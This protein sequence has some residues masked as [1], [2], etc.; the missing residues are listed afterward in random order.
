LNHTG[1]P[2]NEWLEQLLAGEL[3]ASE[4]D[5]VATHLDGCPRCQDRVEQLLADDSVRTWQR[6]M[7]ARADP[8]PPDDFLKSMLQLVP[9]VATSAVALADT[10]GGPEGAPR[11]EPEACPQHVGGYEIVS[12]LGRG[13]M[14]V[15]YKA[16]QPGLGR[17]VAL[18]RLAPRE[19]NGPD[20]ARFLREAAAVARMHHPNIVQVY[21]V[22]Q[23][24]GRPFLALEYLPGGT[25]AEYLGGTPADPR[26][27]ADLLEKV[28]R[29]VHHAHERGIIHRDLKPSNILLAREGE[30]SAEPGPAGSAR[31]SPSRGLVPKVSDFGLAR[32]VTEDQ[33]LTLP[34]VLVG[35]PAYLAPE[36]IRQ[37]GLT[38]PAGD[39][40]ALGVILY[41]MLTGRPPLVGPTTLATLRLVEA[42]EPV[43]PSRLQPHLP[44][45][46]DTIA[47][48]CLHKDPRRRY[49][50]ALEVAEE[51]RRF[52]DGRPIRARPV[53]RLATAWLWCRRNPVVA[54]LGAALAAS[55]L[56]GLAV[57]LVLLGQARRSAA[58][59]GENEARALAAAARAD[60]NARL[61][62][63]RAYTSDLQ[64][65]SQMW[66]NRQY[67]VLQDVLDGQRP[68][69]TDGT[70]RR[71]FEWHFLWAS[72]HRPHRS[73]GLRGQGWD[74]TPSRSGGYLAVAVGDPAV[75]LL[76]AAGKPV[77]TL[78]ATGPKVIRVAVSA[79]GRRVAGGSED[80][81]TRVWE[82]DSG[83]LLHTLAGHRGP[84][85]GLSFLPDGGA[86]V[87]V[88]LDGTLRVWNLDDRSANPRVISRPAVRFH[89]ATVSPDGK[90]VAVGGSD[91]A[92]RLW[93]T[94]TW[95]EQQA[96]RGHA[97]DVLS[98]RFGPDSVLLASGSRD[99]TARLHDTATGKAVRVLAMHLDAVCALDFSPDGRTLATASLDRSIQVVEVASGLESLILLGHTD[100]VTGVAFGLD[101]K[102]L[103]S[104]GWD[105]T[106]RLWDLTAGRPYRLWRGHS[107]SVRTVAFAPHGGGLA[108]GSLDGT[109]RVWDAVTGAQRQ[110]FSGHTGGV[111]SLAV[112]DGG[113]LATAAGDSRV[114]VWD[115]VAGRVA[116]TLEGHT[117]RV[118]AVSFGPGGR[119]L[120]GAGEGGTLYVWDAAGTWGCQ[121]LAKLPAAVACVRFDPTGSNLAAGCRDGTVTVLEVATG[122]RRQHLAGHAGAVTALDFSPDGRRLAVASVDRAIR[123]WDGETGNLTH[124]LRGHVRAVSAVCFSPDGS[125]L[126]SGSPDQTVRV[127]HAESWQPLVILTEPEEVTTLAVDPDE[128]TVVSAGLTGSIR[129]RRAS[130]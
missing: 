80:G 37:P 1:C 112:A 55:V 67:S 64:F 84:V 60:A 59:A 38:T 71:G 74:M 43:P 102:T 125:R 25:L 128:P 9:L 123:I 30:A 103:A 7:A 99:R 126:F 89:C 97:G 87:T 95:V 107:G 65:A 19:P 129:V 106:F 62:N 117:E 13:G 130:P 58:R 98:V 113:R 108:T 45:D 22:G 34:D 31:A 83:R 50:S 44:R 48:A 127:W 100:F 3:P 51:L 86:L 21:E 68:E 41:E 118:N 26:E 105:Q 69:R 56:L 110:V 54:G 29:A 104:T 15:V 24:G 11:H 17:V 10:N 120:A 57:A 88:G 35:T 111:L 28:A 47:L 36:A 4:R 42:A 6:T 101:G 85:T 5:Q 46:L 16:R 124:T 70:D 114:R 122:Q 39:V 23:D 2:E 18:K 14:S 79:D 72:S 63:D 75:E 40:Y 92:V 96:L 94:A 82:A 78:T 20:V 8:G 116:H 33:S 91:G 76:D 12:V 121:K 61:A 90:R 53:G 52:L 32:S 81:V 73:V 119:L 109:V 27:A 115:T 49:P 93:D 77:R 66:R